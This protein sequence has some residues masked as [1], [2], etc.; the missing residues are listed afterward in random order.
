MPQKKNDLSLYASPRL[1]AWELTQSCNLRCV[2]CRASATEEGSEKELSTA[3]AVQFIESL[4]EWGQPILILTGGEP[5]M[6]KDIFKLA[7]NATDLGLRVV[8][9]TNGTM[10]D[11]RI[12]KE[13][14]ASGIK[15]VSVSLD[16]PDASAHDDFRGV[17]GAF[18]QAIKG[19]GELKEAGAEFQINT[20]ITKRN[21]HLIEAMAGLAMDLGARALHIFLLVPTGRGKDLASEAIS[22]IEYERVLLEFF[23]LSKRVSMEMKATCAP[24]YYRIIQQ[25]GKGQ[26]AERTSSPH[27]EGHGFSAMTRGCL[28]GTAFCFISFK[29]DVCP[30]GYLPIVAG[31]IREQSFKEIWHHAPLFLDLRDLKKLKGKCGRC[32]Y[33]M[34]CG[35]CRARAYNQSGDYLGEEPLCV[36]QPRG[37]VDAKK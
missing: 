33:R 1:I 14:V 13:I 8:L 16:G 3:E 26:A 25:K 4:P 30:C 35:G 15:R 28:G 20:T 12:A 37:S 9:A 6:R 34:V 17:S 36:Y 32:E 22:A 7:R 24:H 21:A 27:G 11:E 10:I 23:D 29:G 19:I 2:H 18:D 5:L 31:N